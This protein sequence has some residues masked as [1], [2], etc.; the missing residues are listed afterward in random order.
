MS[1]DLDVHPRHIT[2]FSSMPRKLRSEK[3]EKIDE[4]LEICFVEKGRRESG[5]VGFTDA[6]KRRGGKGSADG[7]DKGRNCRISRE[8]RRCMSPAFYCQPGFGGKRRGGRRQG[9]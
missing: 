8:T 5:V 1:Q 6:I 3:R 2:N 9:G 7:V 4:D